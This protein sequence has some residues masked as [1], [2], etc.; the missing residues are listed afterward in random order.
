MQYICSVSECI[1]KA[2]DNRISFWTHNALGF[3]ESLSGTAAVI[4]ENAA[5][6]DWFAHELC[7]CR[8]I[9]GAIEPEIVP[10]TPG[11]VPTDFELTG[12]DIVTRFAGAHGE[13]SSLSCHRVAETRSTN[14]HCLIDGEDRAIQVLW[15]MSAPGSGAE[16]G[17]YDLIKV[18]RQRR[19]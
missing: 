18:F 5:R 15:M 14:S 4:T 19:V 6:Y 3:C 2:P 1:S 11:G 17:P 16:P 8:A 10:A 9:D 12:S 13:C 7:L